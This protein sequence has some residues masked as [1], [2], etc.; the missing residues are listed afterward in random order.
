MPPELKKG[1]VTPITGNT[2][3]H[4]PILITVCAKSIAKRGKGRKNFD[5][6][7]SVLPLFPACGHCGRRGG[8][9]LL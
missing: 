2:E 1:R 8:C 9:S 3:V 6:T 7:V 4:I 5:E